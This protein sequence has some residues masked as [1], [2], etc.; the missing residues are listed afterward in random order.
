ME[1][2]Q[3]KPNIGCDN[4]NPTCVPNFRRFVFLL[5]T[6]FLPGRAAEEPGAKLAVFNE[7]KRMKKKKRPSNRKSLKTQKENW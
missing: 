3:K 5:P 1:K 7:K 4:L 2:Y 6:D